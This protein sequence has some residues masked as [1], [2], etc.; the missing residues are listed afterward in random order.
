M[1]NRD[2]FI[3]KDITPY[4]A[5]LSFSES[6]ELYRLRKLMARLK[7]HEMQISP[8]QV[9][10]LTLLTRLHKPKHILELGTYT[11][12]SALAFAQAVGGP[13][14]IH[15]CDRDDKYI[16]IAKHFWKKS[17]ADKYIKFTCA[18]ASELIDRFI[19]KKTQFDL[20]FIDADKGNY[21]S[22]YEKCLMLTKPGSLII[23]DN[24][25]WNGEVV[26]LYP[27]NR[28]LAM[29]M[30]NKKI[31]YDTRVLNFLMPYGD[32]MTVCIKV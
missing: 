23:F 19:L 18:D 26:K 9:Q 28:A 6:K 17:G 25:L 21:G 29:G 30:L 10:A 32:G 4:I 20:I 7:C 2:I 14:I 13:C 5:S 27:S 3:D 31:S 15:T 16:H 22:Y 11:G 1:S 24:T 8:M 12:Y